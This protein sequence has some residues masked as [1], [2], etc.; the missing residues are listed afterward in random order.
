MAASTVLAHSWVDC[1]KY[2][3]VNQLCL[4]YGRG[5]PGRQNAQANS[6]YTYL[7]SGSPKSQPMCNKV[8]QS[9]MN[10]TDEFPMATVQPGETV[11]TTWEQNGHL[12]DAN[13]TQI[14]I[15]Y[16]PDSDKQFADVSE[17]DTAMVAGT[18]EFATSHNCYTPSN[19]N[20]ACFGS[21]TVPKDLVPGKVYHFVWFWYF[22]ANPAGEW[23][24][25]CFDVKVESA[26]HVVQ[27]G[28]MDSLIARGEPDLSYILG[29][30]DKV[31]AEVA[32]VTQLGTQPYSSNTVSP[33]AHA[34]TSSSTT[35]TAAS[36]SA[37]VPLP[38]SSQLPA[39]TASA[40]SSASETLAAASPS[41]ARKCRVR[42][43]V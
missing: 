5:Y 2:D 17:K 38:Q 9:V 31:R 18:M 14:K 7:F 4:G 36:P 33:V 15:L 3:P 26:S 37:Y 35:P 13:P 10:Y 42:S 8:Q 41:P 43:R 34:A 24:S 27:G 23:Y 11:Y 19:P 32:D 1:V 6:I 39:T 22:N 40:S 28:S 12:N 16:Y 20:T 21:W 25:T 30:T 29:F